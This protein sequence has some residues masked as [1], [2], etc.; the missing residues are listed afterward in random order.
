MFLLRKKSPRPLAIRQ[1]IRGLFRP[2]NATRSIIITLSASLSVIFS[3]YLIDQNLRA[4]FIE[5]YPPNLP[6]AYF[7]D[8]QS[9]Q[10][11]QFAKILNQDATYYPIIRARL[12]SINGSQIDRKKERQRR[13]DNLARE[14]NLTYR[15]YL[16][17][18]E[19]M[20]QGK[21]LFGTQP[22]KLLERGEVPMSVLDSV[23]DFGNIEVGDLLVF[24]VQG[25]P[26]KARVTSMRSRTES[27]VRPF[28]TLS[29]RRKPSRM[30]RKQFSVRPVLTGKR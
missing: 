16:L 7:L 26:L 30:H 17:E 3:I 25:I 19:Q 21:T 20:V 10:K 24:N 13:R 8:I 5:S 18:D 6:N 2:G 15:N 28:S 9:D 11:D 27:K 29:F 12:A 1:A 14:F 22:E 4:T 23:A